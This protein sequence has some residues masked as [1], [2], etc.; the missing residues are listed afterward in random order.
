MTLTPLL[1]DLYQLT[2]AQ[3]YFLEGL[4][5][6]QASFTYSFRENPFE[7][8]FAIA[9]GTELLRDFLSDW[10]FSAEDC[11]WLATL[12]ATDGS[13]LFVPAFLEWLKSLRFTADVAAVAEGTVV[14]AREPLVRVT[15]ALA[16]CQLIESTLLNLMNFSTLIATKAARCYLAADGDPI[17]EF[18]LRRAQGPDGGVTASRAA[19]VGGCSATSNMVAAQRFAIPPAGTHAHSWIMAHDGEQAAFAAW[20]RASANNAILLVDTYDSLKGVE[21]AIHAGAALEAAGGHFA[22]IRLDSG[23]LAWLSRRA[24]EMLDKAGLTQAKIIAS[25]DLDEYT[26]TSLKD[27]GAAIDSWGVGTRLVTGDGQSALGGIYKM[28][29]LKPVGSDRW[30]PKLKVSDQA[31]KTSTPGLQGLRRYFSHENKPEGDMI[32]DLN[33]TP[34]PG[35]SATIVDPQ[36]MTRQKTF[37]AN[38][39]HS[40]LLEPLL[41]VGKATGT[42]SPL[43]TLR[44]KTISGLAALDTSHTR[45][46]HP[47]TYPVGLEK[48]L[49]EQQLALVKE[50]KGVQ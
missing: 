3:G 26:I 48:T 28:T 27:Q 42:T 24:R 34:D 29:A 10:Q 9:A 20:T 17:L 41:K 4:S 47:H 46:L 37:A 25:N 21:N 44:E 31:A 5:D 38:T 14:F 33:R 19:Y 50:H 39:K 12:K 45:L 49:F 32:Y 1:T 18:G 6:A 40:E 11:A 2:M 16:C 36:D 13:A 22:G 7:G 23:D 30:Q 43:K 8:G 15:G 35:A